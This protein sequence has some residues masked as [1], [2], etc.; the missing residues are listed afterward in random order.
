MIKKEE[1]KR[2]LVFSLLGGAALVAGGVL[3]YFLLKTTPEEGVQELSA[4]DLPPIPTP[5]P[6]YHQ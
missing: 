3:T 6:P 4:D 2:P 1:N 5:R